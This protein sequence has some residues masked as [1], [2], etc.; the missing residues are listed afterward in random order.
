MKIKQTVAVICLTVAALFG[1]ITTSLP[2][3]ALDCA[4]TPTAIIGGD[5][6]KGVD[7]GNGNVQSNAIW[8]I[9]IWVLNIM[10]AGVGIL[11]VAGIAW[12]A[13]LY[14]SASDSAEQVKKAKTIITNVVIGLVAFGFIYTILNFLIPG[15][16]FTTNASST[17]TSS[18]TSAGAPSATNGN[19]PVQTCGKVKCF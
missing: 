19:S 3:A 10:V 13:V 16:A 14:A 4:G 9:L 5:I 11:A 17:P 18:S 6:C 12:A 1:G 2:V 15:G 7:N 8:K